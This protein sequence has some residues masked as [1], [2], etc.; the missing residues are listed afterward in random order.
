METTRTIL[1]KPTN[2]DFGD[3]LDLQT[4]E[5][6]RQHL[7][8]PVKVEE[9]GEKFKG[10]IAVKPPESYLVVHH[11]ENGAFIGLVCIAKYHDHIHY[12]VSH[13][14]HPRFWG[15]GYGTEIIK[16]TVDYGLQTLGLEE[17]YAEAQKANLA[18]VKLLEKTGFE[19]VSQ[20]ERYG[21][22]QVVYRITSTHRE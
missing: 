10:M 17:L 14:L 19:F 3:V 22:K 11:K 6:V 21:E 18:S 2:A 16:T 20:I 8:G 4:N 1:S 7:G 15:K 12:E 5:Q 13:E 9:F